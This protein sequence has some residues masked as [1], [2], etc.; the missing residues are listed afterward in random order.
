MTSAYLDSDSDSELVLVSDASDT[1]LP[2]CSIRSPAKLPRL[3]MPTEGSSSSE[4]RLLVPI[5]KLSQSLSRVSLIIV[6]NVNSYETGYY[7]ST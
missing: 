4:P 6:Y 2:V 1:D 5:T 3:A 7:C